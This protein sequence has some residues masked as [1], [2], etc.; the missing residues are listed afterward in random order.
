[1]PSPYRADSFG[2]RLFPLFP[3]PISPA[4]SLGTLE[5]SRPD[6]CPTDSGRL[7]GPTPAGFGA[8]RP[9][10]DAGL[11]PAE[12]RFVRFGAADTARG[13]TRSGSAGGDAGVGAGG[14]PAAMSVPQRHRR[15]SQVPA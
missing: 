5:R 4:R 11:A 7:P 1:V 8:A 14:L 12:A 15:R 3:R 9:I 13:P 10:A 2:P 6:V